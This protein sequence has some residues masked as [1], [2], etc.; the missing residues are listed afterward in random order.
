[1]SFYSS[2]SD[3]VRPST[4]F[5]PRD[6][7]ALGKLVDGRAKHDH[8]GVGRVRRSGLPL[9]PRLAFH[10]RRQQR[11]VR[12]AE[13]VAGGAGLVPIGIEQGGRAHLVELVALLLGQLQ[14]DAW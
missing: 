9:K 12:G 2:W 11:E 6:R 8:D 7:I 10:E 14:L 3:L 13:A 1:M 4:N 5:H